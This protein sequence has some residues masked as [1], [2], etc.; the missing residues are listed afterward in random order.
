M[1]GATLQSN[2]PGEST[3]FSFFVGVPS[4]RIGLRY[5]KDRPFLQGG[6]FSC[7]PHFMKQIELPACFRLR[8]LLKDDDIPPLKAP[9]CTMESSAVVQGQNHNSEIPNV[10]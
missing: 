2:I 1:F 8:L 10:F 6:L 7:V 5:L 9:G 4:C 3:G